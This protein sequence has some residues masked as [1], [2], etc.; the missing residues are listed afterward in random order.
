MVAIALQIHRMSF[1]SATFFIRLQFCFAG[2]VFVRLGV[3]GCL[4]HRTR[5]SIQIL[6]SVYRLC[7]C[8]SAFI[9]FARRV[10]GLRLFSS[11]QMGV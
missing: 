8:Y 4:C 2:F 5:A 6:I 3:G 1:A 11:H 9:I 7:Y 10:G